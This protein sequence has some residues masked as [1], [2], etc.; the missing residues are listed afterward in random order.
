[1]ACLQARARLQ[2]CA[3]ALDSYALLL[4]PCFTLQVSGHALAGVQRAR[5]LCSSARAVKT[6]CV[7]AIPAQYYCTLQSGLLVACC[8]STPQLYAVRLLHKSLLWR[9]RRGASGLSPFEVAALALRALRSLVA[10]HPAVDEAGAP[11]QP[12]PRVHRELAAPYCLPH[13][14][15]AR[16]RWPLGG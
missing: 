6:R 11:L 1:M 16:R 3:Q 12:L 2:I 8:Q 5:M 10:A 9:Q 15:Q 13:I 7:V 4:T 14:A